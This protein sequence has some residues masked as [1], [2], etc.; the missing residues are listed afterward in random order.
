RRRLGRVCRGHAGLDAVR[1]DAASVVAEHAAAVTAARA[2]LTG[3]RTR[4]AQQ[5]ARLT[6][7]ARTTGVPAPDG[8]AAP[9][10]VAAAERALSG[11]DT[12]ATPATVVAALHET[13]ATLDT[14]EAIL[15][16]LERTRRLRPGRISTWP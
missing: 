12:P 9:A 13:R 8:A 6:E 10:Q 1:R 5:H 11:P 2:E 15:S 14:T 3:V 16:T 4:A 7:L